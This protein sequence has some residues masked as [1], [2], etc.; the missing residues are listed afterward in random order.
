MGI[1]SATI[2]RCCNAS[3][4]SYTVRA[5]THTM[6]ER[7]FLNLAWL[8]T[9]LAAQGCRTHLHNAV[10][11]HK[12]ALVDGLACLLH[13]LVVVLIVLALQVG[14]GSRSMSMTSPKHASVAVQGP[15]FSPQMQPSKCLAASSSQSHS[16]HLVMDTH[17][18][19]LD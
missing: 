15:S 3:V 7:N 13:A 8:I 12:H 17:L 5:L 18:A 1:E 6:T 2:T 19:A 10:H 4:P 14:R 11:Q 9:S 16:Q